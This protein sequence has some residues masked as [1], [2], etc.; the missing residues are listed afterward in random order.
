MKKNRIL[1]SAMAVCLAA[2]SLTGCSSDGGASAAADTTE[3]KAATAAQNQDVAPAEGGAWAA[4]ANVYIDVPAKAGGGTDLY[5]RYLSQ[6]LTEV[7]PGV[8]FIVTNYDTSEVGMEHVKNAAPDGLTLGTCHGGAIIQYLCGSSE[9]NIKDDLKVVGIM[10][11]GGPQ[12]I[13]AKP[14]APYKNFM[15]FA[16]YVK[17]NPG[18]VV[19]G[20]SLGGTTQVLFT[21][22]VEGL[23]GDAGLVNYVQCS[24][25]ADKLT[26]VASGAID[27]ANC[28]IPN[29]Q[30]YDADGKLT[31]LGSL[32]P[33]VA[34]LENMSE[35]VGMEL[36]GKFATTQEQGV[37]TTWDSNYYVVAP[38]DT[39]D[40]VCRAINEAIM[41]ATEVSSFIEGN[42]AMATYIDAVDYQGSVDALAAEWQFQDD[43]VTAMGLKVR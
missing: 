11:Q 32:G 28:S 37:D 21:S 38:K 15:E 6:A 39:P 35:L 16:E 10:N 3:G 30:S 9:V 42:N 41:K 19:V 20:C 43:L 18:E 31:V 27:I 17:A 1:V 14:D 4:G 23:T 36:D 8:N 29:A 12:A 22:L 2:A 40:E 26:N 7:C 25:E 33:K 24:S 5:T 13:I 34:T